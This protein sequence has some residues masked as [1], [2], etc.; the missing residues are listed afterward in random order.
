MFINKG[1]SFEYKRPMSAD[2]TGKPVMAMDTVLFR[3]GDVGR[4]EGS[5]TVHNSLTESGKVQVL[6]NGMERWGKG[7]LS[8]YL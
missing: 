6:V 8:V 2:L 3:E 4:F 7:G 5:A 1:W